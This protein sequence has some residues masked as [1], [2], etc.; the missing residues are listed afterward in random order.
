MRRSPLAPWQRRLQCR[1]CSFSLMCRE[2][3][4]VN[5]VRNATTSRRARSADRRASPVGGSHARRSASVPGRVRLRSRGLREARAAPGRR[6]ARGRNNC[7]AGHWRAVPF[8]ACAATALRCGLA[9]SYSRSA[10]LPFFLDSRKEQVRSATDA[11]VR[12]VGMLAAHRELDT[13]GARRT[14]NR[15]SRAYKSG[16]V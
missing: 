14:R 12:G 8:V 7:A 11:S 4:P 3:A 15:R 16:S 13:S 9:R 2:S 6:H 1:R 5:P 10:I